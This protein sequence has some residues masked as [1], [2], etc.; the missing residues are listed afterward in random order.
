MTSRPR[1]FLPPPWLASRV[2]VDWLVSRR[3][4]MGG[5]LR[6]CMT[7]PNISRRTPGHDAARAAGAIGRATACG[8]IAM[9]ARP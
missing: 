3:L 5:D 9:E 1:P 8:I 6:T 4:V 2:V 7:A